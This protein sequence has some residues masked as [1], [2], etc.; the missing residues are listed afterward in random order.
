MSADQQAL[1]AAVNKVDAG[2]TANRSPSGLTSEDQSTLL[3]F[4]DTVYTRV[5]A[6]NLA[7]ARTEFDKF[8][9]K[10]DELAP[11]LNSDLGKRLKDAVAALDALLPAS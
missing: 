8:S 9:A 5:Q 1:I 2:I 7:A 11:K 3:L 6:G 4:L 10:V